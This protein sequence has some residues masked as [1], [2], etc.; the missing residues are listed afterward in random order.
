MQP[1]KTKIG[2]IQGFFTH[3]QVRTALHLLEHQALSRVE[4]HVQL[5]LPPRHLVARH[6][7]RRKDRS[8]V[9]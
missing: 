9:T 5:P 8:K 7:V 2:I 6:A 3:F 4:A 1:G